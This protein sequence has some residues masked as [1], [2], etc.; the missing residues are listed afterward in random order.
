MPRSQKPRYGVVAL[1]TGAGMGAA[2]VFEGTR[3]TAGSASFSRMGS[4]SSAADLGSTSSAADMG[5]TASTAD[6]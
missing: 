1:C 5:I 2:A 6:V 4:T 3:S